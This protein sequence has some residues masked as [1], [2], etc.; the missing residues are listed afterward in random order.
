[1]W[2][3]IKCCWCTS[4]NWLHFNVYSAPDMAPLGRR[5]GRWSC[6]LGSPEESSLPHSQQINKCESFLHPCFCLCSSFHLTQFW[7]LFAGFR[8]WH[9]TFRMGDSQSE[10][11]KSWNIRKA[12]R[13]PSLRF[14]G[15]RVDLC[16]CLPGYLPNIQHSHSGAVT[17]FW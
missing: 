11:H 1:M 12:G 7:L 2:L 13:E 14:R 17:Y 5:K 4:T 6:L 8:W 16:Q 3:N 10:A 9:L 15:T